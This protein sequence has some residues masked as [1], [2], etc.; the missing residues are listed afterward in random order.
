MVMITN[1]NPI[2]FSKPVCKKE[3][4]SV[5]S[6]SQISLSAK[7]DVFIK[8]QSFTGLNK[9]LGKKLYDD[10]KSI[11]EVS[12]ANPHSRGVAGS[13]PPEWI[14]K[15]PK[16]Q[17]KEKIL[18]FYTRLNS[19]PN[20]IREN[21]YSPRGLKKASKKLTAAFKEAGIISK[22]ES[23]SLKMLGRGSAGY[24]YLI[25]GL[26]FENKCVMKVYHSF[27]PDNRQTGAKIEINRAMYWQ[28]N[29][30][31]NSQ[32]VKYYFGDLNAGY[33]VT[34]FIDENAKRPTR[35]VNPLLLGIIP[36]DDGDNVI[37]GHYIDYGY[38]DK[39]GITVD[40]DNVI[41]LLG[42]LPESKD[43]RYAY[44]KIYN[45]QDK[46]KTWE[47][48]LQDNKHKNNPGIRAGMILALD[49]MENQPEKYMQMYNSNTSS[50]NTKDY[51]I[52]KK[53]LAQKVDLA[54]KEEIEEC[55]KQLIMCGQEIVSILNNK[56]NYIKDKETRK[57]IENLLSDYYRIFAPS[58]Y[59]H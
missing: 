29:A 20:I 13:L 49:F 41:E 48:L 56:S 57:K 24:G 40:K 14:N 32:R 58:P 23:V 36:R 19:I 16:E 17:R 25:E 42:I 11:Q 18:Q 53:A 7:P 59:Y 8:N 39:Y 43:A 52:I 27:D 26:P 35:N 6:S 44:K 33:M 46:E 55:C 45:S 47:E 21:E 2:L 3:N 38:L 15:I 22:K 5:N 4:K 31:E 54:P 10:A 1:L 12:F 37:A 34:K 28:K 9:D 50:K 30:G 51:Y